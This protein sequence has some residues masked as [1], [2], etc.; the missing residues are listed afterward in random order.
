MV[1][2]K[3]VMTEN[4]DVTS[5]LEWYYKS[6]IEKKKK[7][8]KCIIKITPVKYMVK[9]YVKFMLSTKV[10]KVSRHVGTVFS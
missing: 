3:R 8:D 4:F 9:K 6:Y 2:D 7:Q 5:N 10:I 1:T